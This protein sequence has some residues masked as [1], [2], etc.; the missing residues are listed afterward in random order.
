M[1]KKILNCYLEN[2]SEKKNQHKTKAEAKNKTE[3]IAEI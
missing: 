2:K 3:E 1:G